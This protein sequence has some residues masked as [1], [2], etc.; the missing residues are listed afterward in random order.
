MEKTTDRF[1]AF[2]DI[3][4]FKELV[5]YNSHEH[6]ISKLEKVQNYLD[7]LSD[8]RPK[9]NGNFQNAK[10]HPYIFSDSIIIFTSDDSDGNLNYLIAS[11][12][13]LFGFSIANGLPIKGAIAYGKITVDVKKSIY[14]G[15]PLIDAYLLQEDLKYCGIIFHHSMEKLCTQKE[16]HCKDFLF[17][18]PT[19]TK[20]GLISYTNIHWLGSYNLAGKN[21]KD[22]KLLYHEVSGSPRIYID[23]TISM[24]KEMEKITVKHNNNSA[25]F[26]KE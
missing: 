9:E 7:L 17:T 16:F 2:I 4:G 22:L 26:N 20:H 19:P 21:I 3:L 12:E 24:V 14:F 18:T 13:V 6:V 23:N 25:S 5:A 10:I 15:Q 11:C 8:R 1:I